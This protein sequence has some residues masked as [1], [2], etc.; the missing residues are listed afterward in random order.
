M[1]SANISLAQP[2]I[3]H[4]EEI[5][6]LMKIQAK[7]DMKAHRKAGFVGCAKVFD[8]LCKKGKSEKEITVTIKDAGQFAA[9]FLHHFCGVKFEALKKG[10]QTGNEDYELN[11]QAITSTMN[12]FGFKIKDIFKIQQ[13]RNLKGIKTSIDKIDI[14][15]C[16]QIIYHIYEERHDINLFDL[17]ELTGLTRRQ[18]QGRIHK[19]AGIKEVLEQEL[20]LIRDKRLRE[21]K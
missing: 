20:D 8:D 11:T 5:G 10:L 1:S 12:K 2:S 6:R 17:A 7:K 19:S 9:Y 16:D 21:S 3:S 4:E 14:E 18:L 13:K 15:Q